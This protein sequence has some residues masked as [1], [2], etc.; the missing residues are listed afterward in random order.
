[1][2]PELVRQAYV[3][4]QVS[5]ANGEDGPGRKRTRYLRRIFSYG[6]LSLFLFG[7]I[8]LVME[9][10]TGYLDRQFDY[11]PTLTWS[12]LFVN[13]SIVALVIFLGILLI[14][15]VALLVLSVF[16]AVEVTF[17]GPV[18]LDTYPPVSIILPVYNEGVLLH[19]TLSALLALDYPTYEVI[20]VDDGSTDDTAEIARSFVG[21]HDG[22]SV[23]LVE[24]PNG[25]KATALNAGIQFSQYDLVLCVDGD[26][27]LSTNALKRAVVHLADPRVGAVAGNVKVVNRGKG[28]TALQA[29]EYVEGL[30][31][32]RAAQSFLKMVNIIPGPFGLFRKEL[33]EK[34]GWY[35]TATFAEDCDMTLKFLRDRWHVVYEAE[36]QSFT[37]APVRLTDLLKQRYRWTRG[38]IQV[39]RQHTDLFFNPLISWRATLVMWI[40]AFESLVWPVMNVFAT[41]YFIVVAVFF[42]LSYYLVFWWVSLTLLDMATAL[43]CIA[44][45][46]EELRL[47]WYAVPYRIFF[48]L[49]IDVC[50]T[51]AMIEEFLGMGMT[52]GKV[53]RIGA[54][55]PA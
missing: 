45:E 44:T 13:S 38:I 24:K 21:V 5:T 6:F 36:S 47:V 49:I 28:W 15:Y 7:V 40:M 4:P 3:L 1:M 32:V 53:E 37:E 41:L 43:Y 2:A 11:T 33:V 55:A 20:V 25:G 22:I 9:D 12:G 23:R 51:F 50:K 42:D 34:A 17:S 35:S 31:I 14:R 39:V 19:D 29:L 16:N 48:L 52:W 18:T 54:T 46:R 26:S 27:T 10:P 30:S 8:Y